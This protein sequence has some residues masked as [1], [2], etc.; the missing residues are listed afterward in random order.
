MIYGNQ[1]INF[2]KSVYYR[3]REISFNEK[4]PIDNEDLYPGELFN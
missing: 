3:I 1:I 4:F 2:T